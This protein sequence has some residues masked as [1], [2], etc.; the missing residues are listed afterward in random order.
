MVFY[1]VKLLN[2]FPV[3][4]RISEIYGPKAIMSGE[5]LDLKKFSLLSDRT[6]K[7]TRNT[8]LVI[9]SSAGLWGL[10]L[11]A[12]AEIHRADNN[13]LPLTRAAPSRAATGTLFPCLLLSQTE[14]IF[15]VV[16]NLH[17][18]RSPTVLAIL[19]ATTMRFMMTHP[20]TL[21]ISPA[22]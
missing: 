1:A 6:V 16:T 7:F 13:S 17:K 19:L 10:Y 21:R 3:K 12:P 2:Y 8:S 11:L 4:G 20:T 22:R 15:S 18:P 5:A 9:A 14:L